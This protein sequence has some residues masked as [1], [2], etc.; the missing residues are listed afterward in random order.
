[1]GVGA[2]KWLA[3]GDVD[4]G[5]AVIHRLGDYLREEAGILEKREEAS[6]GVVRLVC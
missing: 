5:R 4:K 3:E 1:M 2:S 6:L